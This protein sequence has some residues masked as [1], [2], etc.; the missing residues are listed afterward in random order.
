MG[1]T[2]HIAMASNDEAHSKSAETRYFIDVFSG[3]LGVEPDNMYEDMQARYYHDVKYHAGL[4]D[5]R[6]RPKLPADISEAQV[7]VLK[8]KYVAA[9]VRVA[10]FRQPPC[11][12]PSDWECA[13]DKAYNYSSSDY[14]SEEPETPLRADSTSPSPAS[15]GPVSPASASPASA[16]PAS[17]S[18]VSPAS[19][20]PS[21]V[22]PATASRASPTSRRMRMH[23]EQFLGLKPVA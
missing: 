14:S 6:R 12:C 4:Y 22:S 17:P 13:C 20:S 16:S 21:P 5:K 18:P 2:P 15:P 8:L 7:L 9:R 1:Y 19:A 11:V 10:Y 3:Y 23:R